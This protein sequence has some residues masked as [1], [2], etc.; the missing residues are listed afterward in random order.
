MSY[1]RVGEYKK[2]QLSAMALYKQKP[3]NPYY[4]WAVISL[5]M[6]VINSDLLI[7]QLCNLN[8]FVCFLIT[9]FFKYYSYLTR[10]LIKFYYAPSIIFCMNFEK[11]SQ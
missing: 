6:Q 9:F 2:Q 1:V 7:D 10:Y 4:F 3:K 8:Y 5:V 11:I